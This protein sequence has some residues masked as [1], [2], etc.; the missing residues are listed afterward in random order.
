MIDLSPREQSVLNAVKA[1]KSAHGYAPSYRDICN[2][3]DITSTCMVSRYL[4]SL[5]S[6]GYVR[7]EGG[8]AR[9]IIV[10]Y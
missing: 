10:A 4:Q 8:L 1:F 2:A 9:S 5:A 3:T 7:R 6:K